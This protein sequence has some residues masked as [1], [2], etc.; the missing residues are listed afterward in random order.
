MKLIKTPVRWGLAALAA[1]F[2]A[3][4]FLAC[5]NRTPR[6]TKVERQDLFKLAVGKMEDE[7]DL[8]TDTLQGERKLKLFMRDGIFY[9]SNGNGKKLMKFSSYGDLLSLIY[10]PDSNPE[11]VLLKQAGEQGA[12]RKAFQHPFKDI[13]AVVVNSKQE[14]FIEDTLPEERQVRDE[15][16]NTMLGTVILRFD[17]S[18]SYH[19]YL[20]QEGVGGTPF[21]LISDLFC[22]A[23]DEIVA[24]S[25]DAEAWQVYWYKTDGTLWSSIQV[26]RSKLPLPGGKSEGLIASLDKIAP[27]PG[28]RTL[29]LKVDYY[30]EVF[31]P[32]TKLSTGTE[33]DSSYVWMMNPVSA[34]LEGSLQVPAV[35]KKDDNAF[36]A[37]SYVR[38]YQFLG[39]AQGRNLF[40]MMPDED[41]SYVVLV[42][43]TLTKGM[44][45]IRLNFDKDEV[46]ASSF[47]LSQDGILSTLLAKEDEAKVMWWRLD[48][49]IGEVRK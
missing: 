29:Y 46:I 25:M 40:F 32:Q 24:V 16:R 23:D 12:L 27:D 4:L 15:A 41:D 11:P 2:S 42:M 17:Q 14:I 38:V 31:D 34:K 44:R 18:G 49:T 35:Q 26:Q 33:Y 20:G 5:A 37:G 43:N 30:R 21:P 7:L 1:L 47:C 10:A 13:G 19:D 8:H 28:N 3:S 6:E 39:A 36:S 48:R 9:V 22:T 45:K